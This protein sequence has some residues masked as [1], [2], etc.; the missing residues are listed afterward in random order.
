MN[1]QN[2]F[3]NILNIRSSSFYNCSSQTSGGV[4]FIFGTYNFSIESSQFYYNSAMINGGALFVDCYTPICSKPI[5]RNNTF[6]FNLAHQN[7]GSIMSKVNI[8]KELI[9]Q[10]LF[11]NNK[12]LLGLIF[13]HMPIGFL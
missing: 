2:S 9:I 6:I 4:I 12:L 8:E 13:Q 1:I 7:G 5:I 3:I 11:Q 10:N